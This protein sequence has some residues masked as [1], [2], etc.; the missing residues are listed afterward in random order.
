MVTVLCLQNTVAGKKALR[1]TDNPIVVY[2][3][4]QHFGHCISQYGH[5]TVR[6]LDQTFVANRSQPEVDII[7]FYNKTL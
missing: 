1:Y 5:C 6:G 4:L 3:V 7:V 2:I